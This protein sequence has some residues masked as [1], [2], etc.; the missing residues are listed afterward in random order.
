MAELTE[1]YAEANKL[2]HR[3]S[4]LYDFAPVAYATVDQSGVIRRINL[5][6]AIL[7]KLKRSEIQRHRLMDSIMPDQCEKF[8]A[9]LQRLIVAPEHRRLEVEL[10]P[11]G[12]DLVTTVLIDGV[13][14]ENGNDCQ[15][16]I[17]D[18]TERKVLE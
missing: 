2:R 10:R 18:I 6:G 4:D 7:L 8:S 13:V 5:A 16:A 15:L 3:Y 17:T 12:R 9:F 1:S 11:N 14:D